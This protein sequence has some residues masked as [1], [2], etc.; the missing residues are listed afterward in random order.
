VT[1]EHTAGFT[2][3]W[4]AVATAAFGMGPFREPATVTRLPCVGPIVAGMV[5][6]ERAAPL[7]P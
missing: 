3:L 2:R 5:G 6:L 7:T 1:L 4:P